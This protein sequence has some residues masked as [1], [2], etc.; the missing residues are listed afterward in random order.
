V[1]TS[2]LAQF[3]IIGDQIGRNVTSLRG[4]GAGLVVGLLGTLWGGMGVANAA[5]DALNRVWGV[6]VKARPPFLKRLARSAAMLGTLGLGI[7]ITTV[8]SGI[9]GGSGSTG[10]GLRIAAIAVSTVLNVGLFSVAFRV[11]TA[12]DI[13]WRDLLP[14]AAF[15][16][17]AWE[18]LQALG[19]L[20][21]SHALKGMSQTYGMFAIV[22]GLLGWI[23]LQARVVVYAAEINVV[24][25]K[26]L[27]P[28]SVSP[29][30]FTE[31]DER[32]YEQYAK[33]EERHEEE[34]VDVEIDAPTR[35]NGKTNVFS[36]R[37]ERASRH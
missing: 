15:A 5:Q 26:R 30:P 9:G 11:L 33:T 28:R 31:G 18:I 34:R 20:Y 3:P 10:A 36:E 21:V 17:V 12:P 13:A 29:P 7:L 32:A 19:G 25:A 6:P 37:N 24:R 14:G 23:F 8:L 4:S 22:L 2:A 16:A 35:D 1:R 27:W